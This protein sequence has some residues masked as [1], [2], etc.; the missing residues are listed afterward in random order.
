MA[1]FTRQGRLKRGSY[2][3]SGRRKNP[4]WFNQGVWFFLPKNLQQVNN[5]AFGSEYNIRIEALVCLRRYLAAADP[6]LV[7]LEVNNIGLCKISEGNRGWKYSHYRP[8]TNAEKRFVTGR[9][10][11]KT[12]S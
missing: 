4:K 5:F 10:H 9:N 1:R 11:A 7:A 6:L 2:R 3:H 8:L 12:S